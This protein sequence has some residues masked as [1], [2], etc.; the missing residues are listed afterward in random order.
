MTDLNSIRFCND[1]PGW[2]QLQ[3]AKPSGESDCLLRELLYSTVLVKPETFP[4][5]SGI[6]ASVIEK[7]SLPPRYLPSFF[8]RNSAEIQATAISSRLSSATAIVLSSALVERFDDRELSFVIGH[9][10]GHIVFSH[11][12]GNGRP[13]QAS[14][15]IKMR[16]LA[17][18]RAAE[19]S[20]DRVGLYSCGDVSAAASSL[21]KTATGLD[22]QNVR[23]DVQ[24]FLQQYGTLIESGPSP[25][26]AL[27]SHPM[28]LL[29]IRAL[30]LFSRSREHAELLGKGSGLRLSLVN[31]DASIARD[32][33][34]MSGLDL[35]GIED[36]MVQRALLL[37]SFVV[38][39]S[40]GRLSR[41]EQDFL[42]ATFGDIDFGDILEIIRERGLEGVIYEFKGAMGDIINSSRKIHERLHVF[43][44]ELIRNFPSEHTEPLTDA[45]KDSVF[46]NLVR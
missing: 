40:D 6:I 5:L 39:A 20:A 42:R 9:E 38:F 16:Q 43:L 31:V 7:I 17:Q 32:L 27:S 24:C 23:F 37:A 2:G 13:E 19:I 30:L 41:E 8:V 3:D 46:K 28:F 29:R 12:G 25:L 44:N 45:L 15:L 22:E 35:D 33:S 11:C 21:I 18:Q 34:R 26:E 1:F 14:G 36:K 4:R 10:I